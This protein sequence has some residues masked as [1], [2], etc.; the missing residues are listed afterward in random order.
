MLCRFI[1][2]LLFSLRNPGRGRESLCFQPQPYDQVEQ[3]ICLIVLDADRA[4]HLKRLFLKPDT[5]HGNKDNQHQSGGES[6]VH[7]EIQL[8][9]PGVTHTAQ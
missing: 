6:E 3:H 4:A 9:L 8:N 1:R 7:D 5:G 2:V